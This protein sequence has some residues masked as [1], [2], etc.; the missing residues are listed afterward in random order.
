MDLQSKSTDVS[1]FVV[2]GQFAV[3]AQNLEL[4]ARS[5]GQTGLEGSGFGGS[6]CGKHRR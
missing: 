3:A 6:A 4:K 1:Q 5:I 2:A